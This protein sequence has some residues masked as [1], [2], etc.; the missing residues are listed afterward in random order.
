VAVNRL[1]DA[2]GAGGEQP[3]GERDAE[4]SAS[5]TGPLTASCSTSLPSTLPTSPRSD[6]VSPSSVA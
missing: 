2:A 1:Q 6:S 3:L 4:A 5:A